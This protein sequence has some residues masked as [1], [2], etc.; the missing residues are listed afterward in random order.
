MDS[1]FATMYVQSI[2]RLETLVSRFDAIEGKYPGFCEDVSIGKDGTI[3]W[4]DGSGNFNI[5]LVA[6]EIWGKPSGRL[7]ILTLLLWSQDFHEYLIH[8]LFP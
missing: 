2:G 4:T 5:D 6:F 7:Y 1:L 8:N 3:Y